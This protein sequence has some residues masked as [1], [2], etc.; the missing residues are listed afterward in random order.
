MRNLDV[1][2]PVHGDRIFKNAYGDIIIFHGNFR[3][4]VQYYDSGYHIRMIGSDVDP[5]EAFNSPRGWEI[6]ETGDQFSTLQDAR[7]RVKTLR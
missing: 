7:A 1:P 2:Q 3:F 6:V 4:P 5:I